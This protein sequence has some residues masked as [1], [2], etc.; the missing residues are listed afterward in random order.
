MFVSITWIKI[1]MIPNCAKYLRKDVKAAAGA[2]EGALGASKTF[3]HVYS[4]R[5]DQE[6]GVCVDDTQADQEEY[7]SKY[8]SFAHRK[9]YY[10]RLRH[11]LPRNCAASRKLPVSFWN[12]TFSVSFA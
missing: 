1:P 9:R 11:T 7:I 12:P 10:F 2:D 5:G 8:N 6:H 3:Y 4:Q